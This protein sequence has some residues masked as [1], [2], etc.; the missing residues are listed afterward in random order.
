MKHIKQKIC[1]LIMK[2]KAFNRLFLLFFILNLAVTGQDIKLQSS[3]FKWE[4]LPVKYSNVRETRNM[5]EG[6][7]DNLEYLEIHATTLYPK[8][9]P[10]GNHTHDY[11]EEMVFVKNGKIEVKIDT[12]NAILK[13]DDIIVYSSGIEHG[14]YNP[15]D[16]TATY[17]IIKWKSVPSGGTSD[18]NQIQPYKIVRREGISKI[19]KKRGGRYNIYQQPTNSLHELEIHITSLNKGEVSHNIHSHSNEELIFLLKGKAEMIIN[20]NT[21]ELT[22]GSMIYAAPGDMHY[23]KNTGDS[24]CEYYVMR[25]LVNEM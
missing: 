11:F 9:K 15:S 18:T 3:V 16:D 10:H 2:T 21:Y 24:E 19:E 12:I 23:L 1:L 22:P 8:F 4:G 6:K 20:N 5:L 25:L 13:K 7:T 14:I 17:Y